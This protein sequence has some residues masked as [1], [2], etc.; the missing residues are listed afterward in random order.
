MKAF[1]IKI[2][3]KAFN[4][5]LLNLVEK[6]N[7]LDS[8][9]KEEKGRDNYI[10]THPSEREK[11]I[12]AEVDFIITR[13]ENLRQNLVNFYPVFFLDL[14][15]VDEDFDFNGIDHLSREVAYAMDILEGVETE[16]KTP[17]DNNF[18]Q[19]NDDSLNNSPFN[20]SEQEVITLRLGEIRTQL[21]EI[22]QNQPHS[23]EE[24][25]SNIKSIN[26]KIDELK[27]S[28]KKLGRKDWSNFFL[29]F[30]LNA[31]FSL[32]I[33]QEARMT[34]LNSVKSLLNFIKNMWLLGS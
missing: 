28:S 12:G 14:L 8:T 30:I 3:V 23:E 33:S 20:D 27:E 7:T 17:S 11:Y 18:N 1:E 26:E 31:L 13:Y 29:A 21:T 24:I 5:Y 9:R 6:L 25:Q 19:A 2:Q 32:S 22:A 10:R 34:L 4:N 16:N 15:K